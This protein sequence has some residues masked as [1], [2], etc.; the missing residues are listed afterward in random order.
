MRLLATCTGVGGD[1]SVCVRRTHVDGVTAIRSTSLDLTVIRPI[2]TLTPSASG[3]ITETTAHTPRMSNISTERLPRPARALKP[4]SN[5]LSNRFTLSEPTDA[6]A[7]NVKTNPPS[8]DGLLR[9]MAFT[10][11]SVVCRSSVNPQ[12]VPPGLNQNRSH[13]AGDLPFSLLRAISDVRVFRL[14]S[15]QGLPTNETIS[16]S[17]FY[18]SRCSHTVRSTKPSPM[19]PPPPKRWTTA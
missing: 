8:P 1:W 5:I 12:M 14:R 17:P 11:A 16:G 4:R 3:T 10:S 19:G 2:Q 6:G 7:I 15:S 13:A 9:D 18:F